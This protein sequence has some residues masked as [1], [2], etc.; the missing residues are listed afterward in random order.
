MDKYVVGLDGGGTKTEVIVSDLNGKVLSEFK[1]GAIN[2]S[3]ESVK[4]VE[5]NL[6]NI[7]DT[8]ACRIGSF[9]NCIYICIGAAGISNP[10]AKATLRKAVVNSGYAG[11]LFMTGDHE[12]ALYGALGRADGIILIAGTGSICY[13]KNKQGLEK[14]TGGFGYLI[15]DGGSGYAIGRDILSAIVRAEDGRGK[16]TMLKEMVFTQLNIMTIEELIGF[17]YDKATNKRDI[18]KIAP[19]LTIACNAGDSAALEI[20]VK[21]SCELMKLVMPIADKLDLYEGEIAF[22]G[23]ILQKD[24]YIRNLFVKR[25]RKTYP[26]M[27]WTYPQNG[28]A[29]GA[30][31]MAIEL[32]K[33]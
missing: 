10:S 1:S 5:Q 27:K 22:A 8:I 2:I 11:R 16:E 25:L 18:A 17:I 20:A 21:C 24:E 3:G 31:L 23:S 14:R 32:A 15:D 6:L 12:T 9:D 30:A 33:K 29:Y 13:A 4:N 26:K 28:A 7:F 19:N